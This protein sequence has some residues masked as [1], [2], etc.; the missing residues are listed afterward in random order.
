MFSKISPIS[1]PPLLYQRI[2]VDVSQYGEFALVRAQF[3]AKPNNI[4]S[5]VIIL[6]LYL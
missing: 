1:F 6:R 2:T 4:L 5:E 3:L